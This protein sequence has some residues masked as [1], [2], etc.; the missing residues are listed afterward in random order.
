MK[1]SLFKKEY[2]T[3]LE[4]LYQLR[5]TSGLRQSDL[6]DKLKVPQSLISKIES[7]ERRL[8]L[9]ELKEICRALNTTLEDFVHHFE[10]KLNERK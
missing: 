6:A 8:D 7:G 10:K 4:Q 3:L 5:V 2:K 1:K 9:V